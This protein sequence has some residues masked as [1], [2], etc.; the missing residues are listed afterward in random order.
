[1]QE[2]I[3]DDSVY[4]DE[5]PTSPIPSF[6]DHLIQ[7]LHA[8]R[9]AVPRLASPGLAVPGLAVPKF[10]PPQSFK[11]PVH[12]ASDDSFQDE[13][14]MDVSMS[15]DEM[16][17]IPVWNLGASSDNFLGPGPGIP[18][19]ASALDSDHN[20]T[21]EESGGPVT[22]FIVPQFDEESPKHI[23]T[24]ITISD[25]DSEEDNHDDGHQQ[26]G[27]VIQAGPG[28]GRDPLTGLYMAASFAHFQ[29]DWV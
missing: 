1:M 9:L 26:S 21:S 5:A 4:S 29:D 6:P 17:M 14:E 10:P 19:V 24:T 8:P 7:N 28:F 16:Q 13:D 11:C 22:T 20:L 2:E 27:S 15:D 3:E 25:S 12:I 18:M 23:P